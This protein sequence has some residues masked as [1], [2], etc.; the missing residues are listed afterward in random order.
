LKY[1]GKR[2]PLFPIQKQN[3]TMKFPKVLI[4][5]ALA[6]SVAIY[7]C[8]DDSTTPDPNSGKTKRELVVGSSWKLTT[9]TF[10]P[11]L[12]ITIGTNTQTFTNLF[13]IPL[14]TACQKDNLIIFNNDST[15][16]LDNGVEKCAPSEPQTAKDGNW[17]FIDNDTKILITNSD[18]FS[19]ISSDSVVLDQVIVSATEMRG[20]TDY[21]FTNPITSVET[22]TKVSFIFTK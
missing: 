1:A 12:V 9:A 3:Q 8:T 18:Y 5:A 10:N 13:D 21:I 22:K 14:I 6:L 7:S 17:K 11:P 19:L 16:T 20:V 2:I 4:I 15:M